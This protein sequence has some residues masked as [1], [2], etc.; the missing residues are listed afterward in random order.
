MTLVLYGIIAIMLKSPRRAYLIILLSVFCIGIAIGSYF[1]INPIIYVLFLS[2]ILIGLWL[3]TKQ[4]HLRLIWAALSFLCFGVWWAGLHL[5]QVTITQPMNYHGQAQLQSLRFAQAPQQRAVFTLREG[6]HRG[7]NIQ[8]YIYDW[9]YSPGTVLTID[10]SVQPSQHKS[11]R[12]RNVIGMSTDIKVQV[13]DNKPSRLYAFRQLMQQRVGATIPEPYASLAIGLLTGTNDDFDTNFKHDLQSTGTTHLVAVSGYNLTIVAL[14]LQRI[15]RRVNPNA[16]MLLALLGITG[17]I[18]LAGASPSILRGAIVAILSLFITI[19]GRIQHRLPL[20]L[21]SAV[22]L[23]IISPLGMLYSL[24]WQLSFLAFAGILFLSPIITPPLERL[25]GEIGASFGETLSATLMVVPLTILQFGLISPISPFVNAL[26]LLFTPLAMGLSFFQAVVALISVAAGRLFAWMT[27]PILWL[28]V[29]PIQ[30]A[31]EL[32]FA[33]ISI[34]HFPVILFIVC[35]VAIG[36]FL[37]WNTR[38]LKH[39]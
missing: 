37:L 34:A 11:D 23:S 5:K 36:A 2:L 13:V 17:Y 9:I 10:A 6:T 21:L 4:F 15:G 3:L 28:I 30:L 1:I 27:Y 18:V 33:S 24:S 39:A 38:T 35:Y 14:L 22:I 8:V 32:P 19:H 12:G 26:V 25:G 31:A 7:Q 16:G 20:V 29:R